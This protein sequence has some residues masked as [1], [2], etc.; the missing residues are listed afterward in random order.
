[1]TVVEVKFVPS[2]KP[3]GRSPGY[4]TLGDFMVSDQIRRPLGRAAVDIIAIA[5]ILSPDGPDRDNRP[6]Q[7]YRDSFSV[8]MGPMETT[9]FDARAGRWNRRA[10]V[11][12]S[13]H[14]VHAI[15]VEFGSGIKS[16]GKTSGR[17]RIEKQGGWNKPMRPLGRAGRK[18][19]RVDE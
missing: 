14:S 1:M 15:A 3:R 11:Q 8:Q 16:E 7:K 6:G 9:V 10:M 2:Y 5:K 4:G 18:I 17:E 13:N 19:G 12:I